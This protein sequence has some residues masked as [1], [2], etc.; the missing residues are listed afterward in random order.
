[1]YI[2]NYKK[3]TYS[4]TL[5]KLEDAVNM[6]K[7]TKSYKA[8]QIYVILKKSRRIDLFKNILKL[9]A[10]ACLKDAALCSISMRLVL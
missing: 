9:V 5:E 3:D 10:E 1:M 6:V 7:K 2:V 8:F 4:F